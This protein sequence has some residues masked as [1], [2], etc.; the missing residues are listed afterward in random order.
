MAEF[1]RQARF[2]FVIGAALM[3]IGLV[4]ALAGQGGGGI[5]FGVVGFIAVALGWYGEQ[6]APEPPR[7]PK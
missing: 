4:V 3:V 6:R 7:P 2:F 1:R 5:L